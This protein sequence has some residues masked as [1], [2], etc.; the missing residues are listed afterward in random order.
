M[1]INET[2]IINGHGHIHMYERLQFIEHYSYRR[3]K[4]LSIQTAKYRIIRVHSS[5]VLEYAIGFNTFFNLDNNTLTSAIELFSFENKLLYE[6]AW[7][8]SE[9]R[10]VFLHMKMAHSNF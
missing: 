6:F 3:L 9:S 5:V 7:S 4:L 10:D 8:A 1:Q 2:I